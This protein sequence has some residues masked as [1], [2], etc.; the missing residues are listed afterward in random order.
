M[1]KGESHNIVKDNFK[2]DQV[3]VDCPKTGEDNTCT[4]YGSS[5]MHFRQ[6]V[7][8]CPVMNRWAEWRGDKP[9]IVKKKARVGQGK[10]KQGGNKE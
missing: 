8:H 2:G 4:V 7:G 10:T 9:I 6:M 3:C 5:G 1:A